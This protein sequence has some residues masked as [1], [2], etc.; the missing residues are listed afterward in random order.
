M[1]TFESGWQNSEGIRFFVRGWEPNKRVKAVVI[2]VHGLGD[3][4]GRYAQVGKAFAAAGYALVGFDLRGHGRSGGPRGHTPS[5][6]R[7]LDDLSDFVA[8]MKA[9]YAKKPMFIYGHSM[10]GNLVL[11]FILRRKPKLQGAIVTAPWLETAVPVPPARVAV[12]RA[13]DRILPGFTQPSGLETAGLSHDVRVVEA[14]VHDP[15]VHD[16]ISVRL[17]TGMHDAGSWAANHAADLPMPLLLMQGT[18]DRLVSPRAARALAEHGGKKVTWRAWEGWY[19]EI[20]N[21]P[22]GTRVLNVMTEWMD[23]RL[24][25][26]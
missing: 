16:R 5:Y 22:Q 23:R 8:Q 26:R 12:A 14:Y 17:F 25:A 18:A 7:L 1:K 2:L 4:T 9:R 15:L 19:H 21:E 11:N 13:L 24:R 6:E 20:H 3:H 10:G